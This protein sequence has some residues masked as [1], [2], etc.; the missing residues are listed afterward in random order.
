MITDHH[1]EELQARLG[2]LGR[3]H[4]PS[5]V[6]SSMRDLGLI[7]TDSSLLEAMDSLRR[8]SVGAGPL[9]DLLREPGVSDVVVNGPADVFVDRGKGLER[10]GVRFMDDE[11]VRRLAIRLATSAGRRLDDAQPFV[12]GRLADGTRLH[13]VL[14]P[15]A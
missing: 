6:A 12:D 5:D 3:A 15:V 13:V 7:V 14:A 9:E 11:H 1:L 10:A 4:A 8:N 2:R